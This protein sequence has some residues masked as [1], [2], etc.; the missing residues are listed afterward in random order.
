MIDG[1]TVAREPSTGQAGFEPTGPCRLRGYGLVE[2]LLVLA[3]P[4][5]QSLQ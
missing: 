1:E 5:L 3:M 2:F 4:T